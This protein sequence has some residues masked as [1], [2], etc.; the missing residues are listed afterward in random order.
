LDN[1]TGKTDPI[2]KIRPKY[3]HHPTRTMA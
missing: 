1:E 3:I 2:V